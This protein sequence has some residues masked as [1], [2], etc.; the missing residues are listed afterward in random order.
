MSDFDVFWKNRDEAAGKA[1]TYCNAQNFSVLHPSVNSIYRQFIQPHPLAKGGFVVK[2]STYLKV[3]HTSGEHFVFGG[4]TDFA[5]PSA[6]QRLDTGTALQAGRDY[7]IYLCLTTNA[8]G[9][10]AADIVVSLN[11]T[12]P[13]GYN[14]YTS[15]KLGGFHALCADV[16]VIT[17]HPLSGYLAGEILPASFWDL[18]HRPSCNPEGMVYNK[19]ADVW[20][21]IYLQ[22]GVGTGTRSA[23]GGTV[24]RTRQQ[25]DHIED[26]FRVGKRLLTDTEFASSMEGSNQETNIFGGVQPGTTGGHTDTAGRRMISNI[27]CEDGVGAYWQWLQ[28]IT[29]MV[30]SSGAV[31]T[32]LSGAVDNGTYSKG[33]PKTNFTVSD[34]RLPGFSWAQRPADTKGQQYDLN[35]IIAGGSWSVGGAC[36]SRTRYSHYSRLCC[37]VGIGARGAANTLRS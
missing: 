9:E 23:F 18:T 37:D 13:A 17:A 27:G 16:G 35:G 7:Y 21:D 32:Y 4:E 26:M 24:T 12:F 11:N 6:A 10:N 20:V 2:S 33:N 1:G 15:R 34:G 36:G 22:S 29:S 19:E 28:E 8:A 5:V 25:L 14:A 3:I 30:Y 31:N